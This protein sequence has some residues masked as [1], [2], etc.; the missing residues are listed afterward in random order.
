MAVP[1]IPIIMAAA[2][3]GKGMADSNKA[4]KERSSAEAA[5]RAISRQDPAIA[6]HLAEIKLKRQY[7]ENGQSRLLALK[8]RMITN[9]GRQTQTNLL[10]GSGNAPGSAQQGLLRSQA[11]TQQGLSQAGVETEQQ[12]LGLLNMQTPIINDMA[13]R[14]LSLDTYNRDSKMMQA[15][16]TQ[17]NSNNSISSGVG[18]IAGMGTPKSNAV[19]QPSPYAP[20]DQTSAIQQSVGPVPSSMATSQWGDGRGAFPANNYQPQPQPR[21]WG[22][23]QGPAPANAYQAQQP[24][25]AWYGNGRPSWMR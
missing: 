25:Y 3:I 4:K 12:S 17:Q 5:N 9:A 22:D 19:S 2:M 15:A 23:G 7:A 10:R 24:G 1:I 8:R 16:Q 13:D 20:T 14:A 6:A 21:Q 18:L 11:M